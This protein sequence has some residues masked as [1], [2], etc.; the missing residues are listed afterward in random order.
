MFQY[1]KHLRVG[2]LFLFSQSVEYY[3]LA[4]LDNKVDG[5]TWNLVKT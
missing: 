3:K 4:N 2:E 5:A 1:P